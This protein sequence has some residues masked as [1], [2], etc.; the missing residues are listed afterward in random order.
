[1]IGFRFTTRMLV[2]LVGLSLLTPAAAAADSLYSVFDIVAER[3]RLAVTH[4]PEDEAWQECLS[5]YLEC[6]REPPQELSFVIWGDE[7]N[8]PDVRKMA[9]SL[10]DAPWYQATFTLLPAGAQAKA[11][12][13]IYT[14]EVTISE[15][16]G[17]WNLRLKTYDSKAFFETVSRTDEGGAEIAV[18]GLRFSLTP[19]AG[20]HKK[21]L[22]F[23]KACQ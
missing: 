19:H 11:D 3:P 6:K 22:D 9:K 18:A 12:L 21:L 8:G 23:A 4:C 16:N 5:H 2:G 15:L 10:L 20:D 17:D 1:M 13:V 14:L 7:K